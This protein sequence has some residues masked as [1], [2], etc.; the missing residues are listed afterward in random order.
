MGDGRDTGGDNWKWRRHIEGNGSRGKLRVD[1][2]KKGD[3]ADQ[4]VGGGT[5]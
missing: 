3:H 4:R 5:E 2:G 1:G